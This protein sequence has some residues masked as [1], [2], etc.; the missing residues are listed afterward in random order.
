M[1]PIF[2]K[3]A[4]EC[5]QEIPQFSYCP[6]KLQGGAPTVDP[7]CYL[8]FVFVFVILSCLFHAVLWPPA[9]K[10]LTSWF[11]VM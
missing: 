9:G 5:D 1:L 2:S 11:S 3:K 7:F 8:C 10:G 6:F 4:S